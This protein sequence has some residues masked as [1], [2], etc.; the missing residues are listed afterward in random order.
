M[1]SGTVM[2]EANGVW[3][4]DEWV[5]GWVDENNNGLHDPG[6]YEDKK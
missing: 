6:E 4:S 3:D 2:I 5:D 1:G